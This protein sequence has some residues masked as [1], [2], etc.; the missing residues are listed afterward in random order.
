M[1]VFE[2]FAMISPV[3]VFAT[4]AI[5]PQGVPGRGRVRNCDQFT[6][7]ANSGRSS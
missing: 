7:S 2:R 6:S 3:A 4:S 5:P 1:L